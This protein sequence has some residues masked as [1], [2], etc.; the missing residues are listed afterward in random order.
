MNIPDTDEYRIIVKPNNEG[1]G[2]KYN[3][4]SQEILGEIMGKE[5]FDNTV[6]EINKIIEGVWKQRRHEEKAEFQ[7]QLKYGLYLAIFLSLFAFVLLIA[8]I[9]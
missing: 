9:Q 1:L 5:T 2:F 3:C 6:K 7:P 8:C 4:Y